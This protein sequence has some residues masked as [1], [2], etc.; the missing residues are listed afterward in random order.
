MLSCYLIIVSYLILSYLIILLSYYRVILFLSYLIL[1]DSLCILLSLL[2]SFL[3]FSF[4][5]LSC[6]I[7]IFLYLILSYLHLRHL[8]QTT[9]TGSQSPQDLHNLILVSFTCTRLLP[10]QRLSSW[11]EAI[12]YKLSA[13]SSLALSFFL[14]PL[15]DVAFM[16]FAT[17]LH[18]HLHLFF[19]KQ[20]RPAAGASVI[21]SVHI[22]M[23][24]DSEM[25][26]QTDVCSLPLPQTFIPHSTHPLHNW[27][28]C[29]YNYHND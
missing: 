10:L 28:C 12:K 25:R 6:Y 3:I 23:K 20:K 8:F 14:N 16:C 7:I 17:T 2:L 13:E 1:S 26:T 19:L 29:T 24:K 21:T 4:L 9:F 5:I 11:K 27:S 18:N 15:P 22:V